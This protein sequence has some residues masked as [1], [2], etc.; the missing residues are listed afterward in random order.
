MVEQ[1]S[2][3][4]SHNLTLGPNV[5][6]RI[7][8]Q[9]ALGI[10]FEFSQGA[11]I[12]SFGISPREGTSLQVPEKEDPTLEDSLLLWVDKDELLLKSPVNGVPTNPIPFGGVFRILRDGSSRIYRFDS[13]FSGR[14]EQWMVETQ[15]RELLPAF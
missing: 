9:K 1:G 15:L 2:F 12:V 7:L 8:P 3:E 5:A 11:K 14:P 4:I 6:R 13:L 10:D